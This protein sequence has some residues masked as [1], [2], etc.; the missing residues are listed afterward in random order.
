M[1][2]AVR[3]SGKAL[4]VGVS[5][6]ADVSLHLVLDGWDDSRHNDDRNVTAHG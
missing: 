3:V 5:E 4:P 1:M 6:P 2:D